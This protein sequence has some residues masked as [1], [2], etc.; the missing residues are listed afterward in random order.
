MWTPVE[1]LL[2][3]VCVQFFVCVR[4]GTLQLGAALICLLT[5]LTVSGNPGEF[6]ML[7]LAQLVQ[8]VVNPAC[9]IVYRENTSDDPTRRCPDITKA[10]ALLSW[11]PKVPLEEGL[12][13]MVD[14]FRTRVRPASCDLGE[15][16]VDS[17]T[18]GVD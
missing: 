13:S 10:K 12:K 14:D 17:R 8:K 11:E 4:H 15:E 5:Y 1:R 6:N 9:E 2:G 18:Q 16:G 7:E 3:H